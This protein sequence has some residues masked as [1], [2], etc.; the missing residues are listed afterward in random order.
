MKIVR[1]RCSTGVSEKPCYSVFKY[2][3]IPYGFFLFF[4]FSS[5]FSLLIS[6][7]FHFNSVEHSKNGGFFLQGKLRAA[8][9]S[10]WLS[11]LDRDDSHVCEL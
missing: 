4:F 5:Q 7:K 3:S 9:P 1:A 8:R 2:Q 10:F 6:F 11:I